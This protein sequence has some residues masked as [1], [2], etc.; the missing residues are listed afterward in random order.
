ME[1]RVSETIFIT[2]ADLADINAPGSDSQFL[3][4]KHRNDVF[5]VRDTFQSYV[6][7]ATVSTRGTALVLQNAVPGA[8]N[9][10]VADW[11]ALLAVASPTVG[12]AYTVLAA[13]CTG[14]VTGTQWQWSG[15]LWRPAG[16][17]VVF[18]LPAQ[19]NGVSG[20]TT[21]A[22]ILSAPLFAA[23]VLRGCRHIWLSAKDGTNFV[24]DPNQRNLIFRIGSAGTASDLVIGGFGSAGSTTSQNYINRFKPTDNTTI[25]TF[26]ADGVRVLGNAYSPTDW[27]SGNLGG[28]VATALTV[29]DLT[30]TA[31][32]L[33]AGI[34][35]G[36]SP[37]TTVRL[38][39]YI[40]EVM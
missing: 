6:S 14:G 10:E 38:I 4:P 36:A 25:Q 35:Q 23:G 29:S 17:Q 39:E 2:S 8:G 31:L 5:R 15:A 3:E 12:R 20:G 37:T 33:S 18:D 11:A 30:T 1:A 21:A 27:G 26:H 13:V 22:Q 40:I 24:G 9:Y 28:D 32:Y 19:V 34:T 7:N 16:R